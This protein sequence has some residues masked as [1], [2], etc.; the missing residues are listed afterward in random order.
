MTRECVVCGGGVAVIDG[1]TGHGFCSADG[2]GVLAPV[3]AA[4]TA[5]R[6]L[7]GTGCTRCS[8]RGWYVERWA[9]RDGEVQSDTYD[10]PCASVGAA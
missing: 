4:R 10:C 3:L 5:E 6:V 1:A 7:A 8:G 2:A 9:D